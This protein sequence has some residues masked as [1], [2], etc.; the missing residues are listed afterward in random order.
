VGQQGDDTVADKVYRGHVPSEEHEEDRCED[1]LLVEDIAV[2]L[3]VDQP[4]DH[5]V[6]RNPALML[7]EGL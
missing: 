2:L 4:A 5:V 1:L 6:G 7:E 3:D